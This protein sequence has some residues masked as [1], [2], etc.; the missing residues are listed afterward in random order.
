VDGEVGRDQVLRG[1]QG[2]FLEAALAD[3]LDD[4]RERVDHARDV[5]ARGWERAQR[6]REQDDVEAVQ[7]GIL[8]GQVDLRAGLL[9]QRGELIV[10][11]A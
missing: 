3:G 8:R 11:V 2:L 10:Q 5:A 1:E 9:A 6:D 4:E 7:F